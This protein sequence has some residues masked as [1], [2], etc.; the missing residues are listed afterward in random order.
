MADTKLRATL[1]FVLDANSRRSIK[2]AVT[3]ATSGLEVRI[4]NVR[5]GSRG[6]AKLQSDVE[7]ATQKGQGASQGLSRANTR[8]TQSAQRLNDVQRRLITTQTRVSKGVQ[9]TAI[10]LRALREQYGITG[11]QAKRL[12]D[13]NKLVGS[14]F[15]GSGLSLEN[16]GA[17]LVTITARFATYLVAIRAILA[18]QQAF[19]AS[20]DTLV[21][22]DGILQDLQKVLN[23]TPEGLARISEQLFSVAQNTGRAIGD[24]S[25]SF[26]QFIRQGLD[27][28]EAL[29]RTQAALTAT[30]ISTLSQNEA[31]KLITSSLQIFGDQL[32]DANDI[33]DL[34]SVTGDKAA[35]NQTAIAQALL[36]T[37]GAADTAGVGFRELTALIAATIERTQEAAGKVGTAFK[38]ILTRIQA[39][40][41]AFIDQANALGANISAADDLVTIFGKLNVLFGSLDEVQKT[42]LATQVAGQRQVNIF[43]GIIESFNRA[44]AL[45]EEQLNS[46]GA[47]QRKLNIE[48]Q[49]LS[50]QT[51]N[52]VTNFQELVVALTSADEGADA[53]N[54]IRQSISDILGTLNSVTE[55]AVSFVKEIKSVEV[56]GIRLS[57]IFGALGKLAFFAGGAALVRG[58][59]VGIRSTLTVGRQLTTE[60]G[61]IA[62]ALRAA[63]GQVN[64]QQVAEKEVLA[65]EKQ[66]ES[67]LRRILTV[68]RQIA[69]TAVRAIPGARAAPTGGGG[70]GQGEGRFSQARAAGVVGAVVA[71]GILADSLRELSSQLLETADQTG[72][73]NARLAAA[74]A[75]IIAST[76]EVGTTFGILTGSLRAGILAGLVTAGIQ[77][78]QFA[79]EQESNAN[80]ISEAVEKEAS[81]RF[82][83][84]TVAAT[85]S[86]F[87]Q[88]A[89]NDLADRSGVLASEFEASASLIQQIGF[90]EVLSESKIALTSVAVV[91]NEGRQT[92][93]NIFATLDRRQAQVRAGENLARRIDAARLSEEGGALEG[94]FAQIDRIISSINAKLETATGQISKGVSAADILARAQ[95]AVDLANANTLT[96]NDEILRLLLL[97]SPEIDKAR[98]SVNV[99]NSDLNKERQ[100]LQDIGQQIDAITA[101]QKGLTEEVEKTTQG[102]KA[103]ALEG[104]ESARVALTGRLREQ[105]EA[106][107]VAQKDQRG[108]QENISRLLGLRT[109]STAKLEQ[110]SKAELKSLNDILNVS[111]N[112]AKLGETLA[113]E[114]I[115][116]TRAIQEGTQALEDQLQFELNLIAVRDDGLTSVERL[117]QIRETGERRVTEAIRI[118]EKS[119]GRAIQ[120]L[121]EQATEA[122]KAQDAQRAAALEGAANQLEQALDQQLPQIEAQIRAQVQIEVSRDLENFIK[123]QERVLADS[124]IAEIRR[125]TAEEKRGADNRI[126]ALRRLGDS[127]VGLQVFERTLRNI[128]DQAAR[129]FG[130]VN[131]AIL[132]IQEQQV[133]RFA[134][135]TIQELRQLEKVGITTA[136]R[137]REA[138]ERQSALLERSQAQVQSR[139]SSILERV[140]ASAERV[141]QS[142]Q[143]LLNIRNQIPQANAK[144]IQAQKNLAA[145]SKTVEEATSDLISA[146]QDAADAQAALNFQSQ[147][148]VFQIRQQ[149]GS[150]QSVGQQFSELARIFV[151]TNA[152][153]R[154]SE[155]QRLQF[156]KQI[157]EAQL[158][159]LQEQ[160]SSVQNLGVQAATA[161]AD[162]LAELQNAVGAAAAIAGG[163]DISQFAPEVLQA[164]AGLG[165]LF[166]GLQRAL[167]EFG[168]QE[169]GLDPSTLENIEQE[170][171]ELARIAAESGQEQV[172]A[173]NEQVRIAR[174]QLTQ[175][176]SE[177]SLAQ[178]Q[179][180]I[181]RDQKEVLL[182]QVVVAQQGIAASRLG[183][184][185][186]VGQAARTLERLERQIFATREVETAV[187][188]LGDII[189]ESRGNVQTG[190][191]EARSDLGL[192]I[193]K[194]EVEAT[195]AQVM[196]FKTEIERV[197][198]A[199]DL[200]TQARTQETVTIN[201][202]TVSA[203]NA[204]IAFVNAAVQIDSFARKLTGID[205]GPLLGV[206]SAARGGSISNNARGSLTGGEISGVVSA[207]RREKRAMPVGSRLMLANTSET[208]LT[209]R[210]AR[211]F[212]LRPVIK[213]NAQDGNAAGDGSLAQTVASLNNGIQNLVNE[214]NNR[215]GIDQNINV[216]VDTQRTV[217][218]RGVDAVNSAIRDLLQDRFSGMA[219]G[220][221]VDAI[222]DAV[223]VLITTLNEKGIVT[224]QGT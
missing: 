98:K 49:K 73:T 208:V 96:T 126:Q 162:Q 71:A 11:Q 125:I 39:N 211:M 145:A 107:A 91:L 52:L 176:E 139:R 130:R 170:M 50:T 204:R 184:S 85:G 89:F 198:V 20:L 84:E 119:R 55:T 43:V 12:A 168:L 3:R 106:L 59:F 76:L 88:N 21:Q 47:A 179:L 210:Q 194:Q 32:R 132:R 148:A 212:G 192:E 166:P 37:A 19:R 189:R 64:K 75:S 165:Q 104:G 80:L 164:V 191:D 69:S 167:A 87:L 78:I 2:D 186:T 5:L 45:Q 63:T 153:I 185:Q 97:Q 202:V 7:R 26:G 8:L 147:L 188:D 133:T 124:R 58:I 116:Q 86:R 150:F 41:T 18:A 92:I 65:T 100:S 222:S 154:S 174:Q 144:I 137:L 214:L 131:E 109:Q 48:Q 31:T 197:K 129:E 94:P 127:K 27:T 14:S 38:T 221:E 205:F 172:I 155:E 200:S 135:G 90:A 138:Q 66:R 203:D 57:S 44:M 111:G 215:T 156:A 120:R 190:V 113:A 223:A 1:E 121:R 146:F 99:L 102:I 24:V 195:V 207:A 136:E 29:K 105:N 117:N 171:I 224:G 118:E 173:A 53:V 219:S 187:R 217:N 178:D 30:S 143:Q 82:N 16:F 114:T 152:E 209:R 181:A 123:E 22:F 54:G 161:S 40:R 193:F 28:E 68:S 36:R 180:T 115:A 158:S 182:Q 122:R 81:A 151:S 33:L 110:A 51:Q 4:Q 163:A 213:T 74:Q 169:L 10:R 216:Q 35:T 142:E 17:R 61:N 134:S 159:I 72:D 25:D 218:I 128:P 13:N 160:F 93:G 95:E 149:T 101:S 141:N 42:Q 201:G 70:G 103:G 67:V 196:G 79:R 60:A 175:A 206:I 83:A 140:E 108:I 77:I 62:K 199:T 220:E 112:L 9:T 183:F 15:Q 157:A 6:K 46:A 56:V 177:K 34:I 23:D